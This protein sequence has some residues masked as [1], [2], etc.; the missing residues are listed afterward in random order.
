ME[1]IGSQQIWSFLEDGEDARS[2]SNTAIRKGSGFPV[3]S[4]LDLARRISA[5]Q[6]LNRDYVLMFRGQSADFLNRQRNTS[7]KPTI[8]RGEMPPGD[9]YHDRFERLRQAEELLVEHY[10]ATKFDGLTR[11][12]RQRILRWAI[13]QHYE[14]CRTPLLDVTHSLRIAAS[15]ATV[16]AAETGFV[17]VLGLPNISGA[18]TASAEAG[19]QVVRL[20]SVCPPQAVRPHIQEGYLLGEYPDMDRPEQKHLYRSSEI[21]FGLRLIAKFRFEPRAFWDSS[22]NFPAV[23]YYALYP[24]STHDRMSRVADQIKSALPRP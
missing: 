18:I 8:A 6:Y 4:Y 14:I 11:I 13:L 20:S 7:L 22:P 23:P 12:R 21:D 15:F 19:L 9:Q 1:T 17:F 3:A 2:T 5:L 16:S 10:E 24:A